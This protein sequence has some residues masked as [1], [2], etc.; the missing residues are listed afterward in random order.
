[1]NDTEPLI[2]ELGQL[3]MLHRLLSLSLFVSFFVSL[4]L[5][6]S[7][8]LCRLGQV[9]LWTRGLMDQSSRLFLPETQDVHYFG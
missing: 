3:Q 6:F 9:D 4:C 8:L 2:A 7:L 1:M 5:S